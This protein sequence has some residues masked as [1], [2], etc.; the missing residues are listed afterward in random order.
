MLWPLQMLFMYLQTFSGLHLHHRDHSIMLLFLP[1]M[2]CC[3]ALKFYLLCSRTR[4]IISIFIRVSMNNS[5]I[6]ER[7]FY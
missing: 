2:L 1:I 4:I 5:T 3:S 7:L 6:V